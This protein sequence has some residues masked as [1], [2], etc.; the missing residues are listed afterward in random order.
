MDQGEPIQSFTDQELEELAL[1]RVRVGQKPQIHA[2]I[3]R[4]AQRILDCRLILDTVN[5]Y[6]F[7]PQYLRLMYYALEERWAVLLDLIDALRT[8]E[9]RDDEM[10]GLWQE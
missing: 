6:V 4:E 2:I 10:L 3:V 9:E 5:Q 8:Q 7:S 1:L